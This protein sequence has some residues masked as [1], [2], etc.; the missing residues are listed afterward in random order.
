[1][2]TGSPSR[3]TRGRWLPSAVGVVL[4][5]LVGAV[6]AHRAADDAARAFPPPSATPGKG[7]PGTAT[8][9][10]DDATVTRSFATMAQA[11]DEQDG[12]AFTAAA[13]STPWARVTWRNLEALGIGAV[14]L[15]FV[16]SRPG[17]T[18]DVALA[19][20]EV[21]WTPGDHA[22]AYDG[23]TTVPREVTFRVAVTDDGRVAVLGAGSG[24]DRWVPVWLLGTLDVTSLP[25]GAAIA[26]GNADSTVGVD[27][28]LLTRRA[29]AAVDTVLAD[30]PDGRRRQVVVVAPATA[31]EAAQLL[32]HS[33][34]D[35]STVAAVTTTVDGSR[36]VDAPV[37]VVLNPVVFDRLGPRGAQ[38]VVSH[39]ATHAATGAAAVRMPLWVAEG[40]ADWVALHDGSVPLDVSAGAFLTSVR[41]HGP[42]RSLPSESD[43]GAQAHGLGTTYEA[44]WTIFR[45]LGERFGDEPVI[46]FYETVL[47]GAPV[48]AA[49]EDA[50]GLDVAGLAMAWRHDVRRLARA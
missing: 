22:S 8:A 46:A 36:H 1:V 31:R 35:L 29:V 17:P 24:G 9:V 50:T 4:L 45:L 48:Q 5:G 3:A 25:G 11:I 34:S 28:D 14:R 23:T 2:S 42:P 30:L 15:R 27:V 7:S 41:Q 37:Q 10:P 49:L 39:E 19:T 13:G 47:T 16:A 43:F 40:F 32:G 33:R 26:V 38:V 6:V 44:A 21:D 12:D 20:V 18:P